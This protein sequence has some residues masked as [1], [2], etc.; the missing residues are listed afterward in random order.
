MV[1][2]RWLQGTMNARK[3]QYRWKLFSWLPWSRWVSVK[4]YF[5]DHMNDE[6][7]YSDGADVDRAI[8][9]LHK[10]IYGQ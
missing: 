6:S 5:A 9:E 1:E 8:E 3:L 4:T 7:A 10:E 2:L